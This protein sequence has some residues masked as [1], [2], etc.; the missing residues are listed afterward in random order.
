MSPLFLAHLARCLTMI[1]H[2]L[3]RRAFQSFLL[4]GFIGVGIPGQ[5]AAEDWATKMFEEQRHDF[6]TVATGA[7]C[8]HRIK[9]TNIYRDD[10]QILGV[11]TSCSC[12][13]VKSPEKTTLASRE[14]TW[15]EFGMDTQRH[16]RQKDSNVIVSVSVGGSQFSE[17]R[18]PVSVYIRTDIVL[19]PG[20]V[21]FGPVEKGAG[22]ER[23]V[24]ISY[25][26]RENW[27]INKIET[28]NPHL[29]GRVVQTFRGQGQV[30]YDLLMTLKPTAPAGTLRQQ[31]LL[32]TDDL[33]SPQ[34]PVQV[35]ARVEA[36]ITVVPLTQV[37]GS[38][39]PG[40]EK[41]VNFVLRGHKPFTIEKIEV[42]SDRKNCKVAVPEDAKPF[43]TLPITIKAPDD[44]GAFEEQFTVTIAGRPEP[45]VFT[46]KGTTVV[47]QSA[48]PSG[49]GNLS[50]Q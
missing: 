38:M 19:N 14:S 13:M 50:G 24:E 46:A 4:L 29:E 10:V 15:L 32:I 31:V 23:K 25:A 3:L 9:I 44:P 33:N 18:I 28:N 41:T 11:R 20:E 26:G 43:H 49:N 8:W 35:Q 47:Q 1:S 21:N 5:L 16:M 6:G 39:S 30:K 7:E 42:D 36:D 34:V 40:A 48:A 2:T 12:A 37:L 45:I 27:A 17:V 22:G